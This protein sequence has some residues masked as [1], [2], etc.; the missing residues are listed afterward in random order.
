MGRYRLDGADFARTIT[1]FL[2]L[3]SDFPAAGRR[4]VWLILKKQAVYDLELYADGTF[5]V[6]HDFDVINRVN[7]LPQLLRSLKAANGN[8]SGN[9]K[10]Q[11]G[12]AGQEKDSSRRTGLHK[13]LY[14]AGGDRAGDTRVGLR[15]WWRNQGLG[16]I[17]L[18]RTHVGDRADMDFVTAS[19]M[20]GTLTLP[21]EVNGDPLTLR[22]NRRGNAV[23][24]R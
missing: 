15:G 5:R 20:A 2:N 13:L 9:N 10:D 23:P 22:L 6:V 18:E 14:G 19:Y 12:R 7:D 17:E 3:G 21:V 4:E 24:P 16:Q 1:K 8:G 11:S